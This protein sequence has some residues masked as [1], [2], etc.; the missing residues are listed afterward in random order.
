MHAADRSYVLE[1][2]ITYAFPM[3]MFALAISPTTNFLY[4]GHGGPAWFFVPFCFPYILL[5]AALKTMRGPKEVRRWYR[6]FFGVST[7][8]YIL[9]ALPLSWVGM[10]SIRSSYGLDV[11]PWSFFAIMVASPFSWL[12]L[13]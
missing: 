12:L 7:P 1:A 8:L 4:S 2:W 3:A 13:F 6:I 9:L 10:T 11:S 5:R